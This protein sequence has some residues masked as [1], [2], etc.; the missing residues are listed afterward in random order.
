MKKR[1]NKII[2]IILIACLGFMSCE[3]NNG[4]FGYSETKEEAK[5]S[6]PQVLEYLPN[7]KLFH[8]LD[9]TD[10]N[11]DTAWTEPSFTYHNGKRVYDGRYGY[12]FSIPYKIKDPNKFTF[13]LSLADTTN[14][15][16]TNGMGAN[17]CQLAP[18]QLYD[19]MK[20][21]LEQKDTDTSK[22]WL[23]P[24]ITDTITFTRLK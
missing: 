22:G 24:I 20:V 2:I 4:L 16:F 14:Q 12:N 19:T 21:L 11:V 5:D 1:D 17:N 13:V 10:M 15:M 9:G 6:N 18:K 8:L 23:N 7:K 3:G